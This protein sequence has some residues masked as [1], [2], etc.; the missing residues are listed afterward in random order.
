MRQ[1]VLHATGLDKYE[2]PLTAGERAGQIAK[3]AATQGAAELLGQ[4]A[5]K[6]LRPTLTR[7]RQTLLRRGI[8]AHDNNA[9]ESVFQDI[10]MT[11]RLQGNKATTVQGF[12][13]VLNQ[14]KR[15]IGNEVDLSMAQKVSRGDKMVRWRCRSK[16]STYR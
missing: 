11:E 9:L 5:E 3:E 15:N 14:A 7:H 4:G 1:G 16:Y 2:E 10:A 6:M 12:V 13:N 8:G